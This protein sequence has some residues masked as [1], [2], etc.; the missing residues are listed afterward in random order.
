V[1]ISLVLGSGG[2]RGYAHIGVIEELEKAG[3]KIESISGSSIGAL[4]GG[5]YAAGGLQE[6]KEWVLDLDMFDVAVLLDLSFESSGLIRGEKIFKKLKEIIGE[7]KIEELP[8]KFT[9]VATNLEK[10]KEVWF[11]QGDLLSAIRASISI[12][13]FFTPVKYKEMVLVDGGVLNPLPVAPTMSDY[14]QATIAVSLYGDL[15]KPSIE[16]PTE[17]QKKQEEVE[18]SEEYNFISIISKSFDVMQKSLI[19]YRLAGYPPDYL[20][21]IPKEVCGTYDFYK[22]YEVIEVGRV[23]AKQF[24]ES[25]TS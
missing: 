25:L 23:M 16:L 8:K 18:K 6:Y 11:Q 20:I 17:I 1:T 5:L 19:R 22:A 2:A 12:P 13:S 15:P 10:D 4:I 3:L 24:L 21:E 14:T 7:V 9:A